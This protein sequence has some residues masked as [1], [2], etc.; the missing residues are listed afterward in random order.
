MLSHTAI[1]ECKARSLVGLN[2]ATMRYQ[3]QSSQ[4]TDLVQSIKAIAFER[5]R[6]VYRRVHQL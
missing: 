5:C 1:S 6:F 4:E 3:S 2:R